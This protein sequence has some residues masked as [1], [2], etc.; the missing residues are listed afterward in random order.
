MVLCQLKS[1]SGTPLNRPTPGLILAF[2]RNQWA[3]K[4]S[5]WRIAP[6]HQQIVIVSLIVLIQTIYLS[7]HLVREWRRI[8]FS[9]ILR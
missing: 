8:P 7:G 9:M 5:S 3:S 4:F 6:N 1:L 2:R